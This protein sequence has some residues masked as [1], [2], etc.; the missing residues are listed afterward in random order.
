[1]IL[2][3]LQ[4]RFSSSRLP[5]KVL[6]EI[7]GEPMLFR[8]IE[9]AWRSSRIEGL[10]V[11][12]SSDVSDDPLADLCRRKGIGCFRGD[13][14]D[15]LDRFYRASLEY[16]P[17]HVIRLTGDCPLLDPEVMDGVI[18]KHIEGDYDYT[19]NTAPPTFPDG[20]DVEVLRF[21]ALADAWREARLHSEREHVTPFIRNNLDRYRIGNLLNGEDLSSLR[22]T[23]DEKRDLDFVRRVYEYLYSGKPAFGMK[24]VLDLLKHKPELKQINSGIVRNEG[25]FKSLKEDADFAA[26][27]G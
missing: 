5:G 16:L 26:N 25:Y 20:L 6:K 15:V 3:V 27:E 11:A 12:T 17:D 8:Q 9:R 24:D 10:I 4:A 14:D 19:S 22:W 2:A 18:E 21:S 13:L 23:V 7:L 1:M